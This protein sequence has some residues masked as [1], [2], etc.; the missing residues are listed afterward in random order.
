MVDSAT[1]YSS[2]EFCKAKGSS[3][4]TTPKVKNGQNTVKII[5]QDIPEENKFLE[6]R[7]GRSDWKLSKKMAFTVQATPQQKSIVKLGFEALTCL[8]RAM[9]NDAN[10]DADCQT[11]LAEEWKIGQK[12]LQFGFNWISRQTND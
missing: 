2:D 12:I 8:A 10:M 9:F 3:M 4:Q 6:L 1:G 7:T 5:H 11:Q